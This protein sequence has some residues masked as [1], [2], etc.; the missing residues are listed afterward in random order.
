METTGFAAASHE[1]HFHVLNY[2]TKA[3]ISQAGVYNKTGKMLGSTDINGDIILSLPSS[4]AS[5]YTIKAQGFSPMSIRLTQAAKTSADYEVFLPPSEMQT[6][7]KDEEHVASASE[8]GSEDPDM[9]KIYVKQEPTPSKK[10]PTQEVAN[11]EFAVQLSATSRPITDKNS[12]K[13]W[14]E[15]GHVFIQNEGGLYKVRIG[16]YNS[17]EEAKQALLKVK[18][19]GRHDAFIVVQKGIENHTPYDLNKSHTPESGSILETPVMT[20]TSNP[21]SNE[22]EPMVSGEDIEYKVRLASYLKPGG[23][24]TK[25]IDQYG[26]LE[27]YRKG[28]WTIMM[29]GGF[30]TSKDAERVRDVA[31]SKGYKDARVV[32]ARDGILEQED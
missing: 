5:L 9:V 25:D 13:A 30:K 20:N 24:N 7:V 10:S 4:T 18:A 11:V 1:A 21:P 15:I 8:N 2:N 26:P 19:K 3:P 17:Q 31:I 6:F 27:S 14:E 12:L 28:E 32:M 22:S 16:P 29:I 23:F